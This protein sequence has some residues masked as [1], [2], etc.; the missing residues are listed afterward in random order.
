MSAH[1]NSICACIGLLSHLLILAHPLV[2]LLDDHAVLRDIF[3]HR[4]GTSLTQLGHLPQ[5]PIRLVVD[6]LDSFA[7]FKHERAGLML[8]EHMLVIS[9]V[10]V[11]LLLERKLEAGIK[12]FCLHPCRCKGLQGV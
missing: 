9:F 3:V 8:R 5:I 10:R 4:I 7:L 1:I 12:E 6:V 11:Q 2:V